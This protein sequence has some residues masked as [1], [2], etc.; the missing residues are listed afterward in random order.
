M[1]HLLDYIKESVGNLLP[2]L[3]GIVVFDIDDTLLM[4]DDSLIKVYKKEPG[5]E[6]VALSTTEYAV[7]PD[8]E[9]LSKKDWFD[10][11]D[12]KDP[13]KVYDSI[14]NGKPLIRN[15]RIMDAYINAGYDF[16][17]LTARGCEDAIK[18]ALEKFLKVRKTNKRLRKLG[19]S[20]N[21]ALS[22]A[23]ND[24]NKNYKGTT[25][26]D[27]KANILVELCGKYDI[28]VFVDDD[29]KNIR[30]AKALNMK[31][32]KIIKAWEK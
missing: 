7:D 15:L 11:R 2:G 30:A 32:L 4:A 20:F 9:D 13:K 26:A 25:D 19:K 24:E 3:K 17:F 23:V 27:K 6:E 14:V 21:K 16:C 28:V 29:K 22:Y 1:I 5:K 12:F 10:Y 18:D 8:T 31:N